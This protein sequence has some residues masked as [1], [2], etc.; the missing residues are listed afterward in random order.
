MEFFWEKSGWEEAD[1]HLQQL[2]QMPFQRP[3][4]AVA[5][6]PGLFVVRG[7]RQIGKTSLLKTLL[8]HAPP[9]QSFYASC[10]NLRDHLDLMHLMDSVRER[11]LLLLDE[12]CFVREWWRAVK[13]RLDA[14]PE[15]KVVLTGSNAIDVRKGMDSMPGRW[16]RDGEILL[17]PMEFHEFQAMRAQAGWSSGGLTSD[18]ELFFRVGGFPVALRESGPEGGDAPL[19][20]E[21]LWRWLLGD[22]RRLNKQE[23]YLK[24]MLLQIAVT[25]GSTV[26]L[27]KLAQRTQMGSHNTALDYLELLEATF[28]IG[29][30]YAV[31]PETGAPRFRKEKKFYFRDPALFWM[32]HEVCGHSVSSDSLAKV[33]EAAAFEYLFRRYRR[34]G[35]LS[36]RVGEIDFCAPRLWAIEVKWSS[37]A[38]NLSKAFKNLQTSHKLVWDQG[39]F[40]QFP[41]GFP[42]G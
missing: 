39:N 12:V 31:D 14:D 32:A 29:T 33:A 20:R 3:M 40:F 6:G 16:G 15:L 38:S 25:T 36:S 27:Q 34:F 1:K 10:E 9:G 19:A 41:V 37:S 24:E 23:T 17:L 7:P 35:Y 22:L 28:A 26:S 42:Q 30:L 2:R 5:P 4:P 18:L 21:T 13:H 8:S 11:K